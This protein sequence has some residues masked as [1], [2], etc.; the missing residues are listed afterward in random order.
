MQW[1]QSVLRDWNAFQSQAWVR[2]QGRKNLCAFYKKKNLNGKGKRE[3]GKNLDN[4]LIIIL[5]IVF[6]TGTYCVTSDWELGFLFYYGHLG[7]CLCCFKVWEARILEHCWTVFLNVYIFSTL[8]FFWFLFFFFLTLPVKYCGEKYLQESWVY[9]FFGMLIFI[10]IVFLLTR[11]PSG[12]YFPPTQTEG[13][14]GCLT[15]SK[16]MPCFCYLYFKNNWRSWECLINHKFCIV[17]IN[18]VQL[19]ESINVRYCR[20]NLA[21]LIS[22][23]LTVTV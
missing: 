21:L 22:L 4:T 19:Y 18:A 15:N 10:F 13:Q 1:K 17:S 2:V 7:V 9:P 3:R 14:R 23:L 8:G 20:C 11:F 6:L 16:F 12:N 5:E